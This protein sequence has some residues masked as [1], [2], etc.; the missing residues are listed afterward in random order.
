MTQNLREADMCSTLVY[1]TL[2]RRLQASFGQA[3][4]EDEYNGG[5]DLL[6]HAFDDKQHNLYFTTDTKITLSSNFV[7]KE[8]EAMASLLPVMTY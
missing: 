4:Y 2:R 8:P 6:F 1:S 7:C 5:D 3:T